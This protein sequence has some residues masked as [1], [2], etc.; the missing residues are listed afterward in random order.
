[1]PIVKAI[2]LAGGSGSR[3]YPLTQVASKQLQAVFDKPMIYYPLTTL[4]AAGIREICLISTPADLPRYRQL[5]GSGAGWG[6]RID[7][8]EQALPGGIAQAFL[9]A[10]DFV[11]PDGV[12]LMLGDNIFS[13]GDD[14]SRAVAGFSGGATIF[15]Y[16]VSDPQ[17]YGVVEFDRQGRALSIEEKPARPRTPYAVTGAYLYDEQVVDIARALKPSARDELE[18]TDVSLEYLRRGRLQVRRLE[19]GFAW[20]DAGTSEALHEASVYVASIERRQGVKI[21]CP[22][23]A[24][25]NRGFLSVDQFE[26]LAAGLPA[27]EYKAYLE[28]VATQWRRQ[29]G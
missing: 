11:S 24:A 27:C 22:E 19:G 10:G 29:R 23:E 8:R 15:A 4:I 14:F 20:L 13:G 28:R 12:A 25:L 3:L 6:I 1:M 7:Y 5:L 16:P 2:L 9:I 26:A 17:R 21:G 18:I